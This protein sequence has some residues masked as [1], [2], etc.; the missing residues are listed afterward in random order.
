MKPL[1]LYATLV[2]GALACTSEDSLTQP[3]NSRSLPAA[4]AAADSWSGRAAYPGTRTSEGSL[5][6]AP[7][8][9]GQ[10]IVYYLG[11]EPRTEV[12]AVDGKPV[13]AY[14]VATNTWTTKAAGVEVWS[15]NGAGKIGSR[16]YFSGGVGVDDD[17]RHELFTTAAVWA[18]DYTSDRLIPKAGLP[19]VSEQG[20]SG[21]IGEKLYVLPGICSTLFFP[22]PGYCSRSDTRRFFRYDPV[23]NRWV[24]RPWAPHNHAR[25]AAGVI[26]GKFYVVG[27]V[28]GTATADLDV[29]DPATNTW[30]TLAPIP[31]AGPAIGTV[32]S[33]KFFVIVGDSDGDLRS[34]EY[35]PSTN[36]WKARAAP[37]FAHDGVVRV[38]LDGGVYLLAVG[39]FAL[40]NNITELYTP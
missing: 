12:E 21:V 23:A 36:V 20:V 33:G 29:Y 37:A 10:S 9:G 34:Y 7:N 11:G 31:T 3:G 28:L 18:Y 32:L 6:M 27:G 26:Q 25:G 15:T 2:V 17:F 19:I 39:R 35:T 16:I 14:N 22:G 8:A 5:A 24:G 38:T 13:K 40:N 1:L 30:T 4:A